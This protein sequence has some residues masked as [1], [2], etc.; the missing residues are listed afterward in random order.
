MNK[1]W[2]IS[3]TK[4]IAIVGILIIGSTAAIFW[5][6]SGTQGKEPSS[7]VERRD[8]G[9]SGQP[10]PIDVIVPNF[11]ADPGPAQTKG[12]YRLLPYGYV[13]PPPYVY[14]T[15]K[16]CS[17]PIVDGSDPRVART[18]KFY[19]EPSYTPPGFSPPTVRATEI[20][21][22]EVGELQWVFESTASKNPIEMNIWKP[23]LPFDIRIPPDDSWAT[24]QDGSINN[25]PAIFLRDK[26]G[27]GGGQALYLILN[28]DTLVNMSAASAVDFSELVKIASSLQ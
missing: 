4:L 23:D 14:P 18:A 28:G 6:Q 17:R 25:V 24:L 20:C 22:T 8:V 11:P 12:P 15:A 9:P 1:W 5:S 26:P 16:P 7:R 13:D 2:R 21:G 27:Q 10:G 19:L 3:R